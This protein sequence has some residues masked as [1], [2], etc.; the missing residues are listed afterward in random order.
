LPS[1]GGSVSL[2]LVELWLARSQ[3]SSIHIHV[4]R[5]FFA[6]QSYM[7]EFVSLLRPHSRYIT[8]VISLREEGDSGLFLYILDLCAELGE[9]SPVKTLVWFGEQHLTRRPSVLR[10]L[11]G[12]V[13]LELGWLTT[14]QCPTVDQ[15]ATVLTRNQ[16]I[17]TLRLSNVRFPEGNSSTISSIELPSLQLLDLA[18]L[19]EPTARWLLGVLSPG[20]GKLDLR[21]SL[22]DT[23]DFDLVVAQFLGRSY[24]VSLWLY[25]A[26]SRGVPI[27]PRLPVL[28][29][30][31]VLGLVSQQEGIGIISALV[32][33]QGD[34]L[35][36]RFPNLHSLH[37]RASGTVNRSGWTKFHSFVG[38]YSL[39]VLYLDHCNL[40]HDP[41]ESDSDS[42]QAKLSAQLRPHVGRVVF[43]N[44]SLDKMVVLDM[45]VRGLVEDSRV[46]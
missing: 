45:Y 14:S 30:V 16:S 44:I 9:Q 24:I 38:L 12:L 2:N 37:F 22:F 32:I 3:G 7:K 19:D 1:A 33:G 15:L 23:A 36:P 41:A 10:R 39:S 43:N 46:S 26:S 31:R 21:I 29:S 34:N 28:P 42:E 6:E 5:R 4:P 20:K 11:T 27:S 13:N 17:R 8:S 18:G 35:V 40:I 25:N